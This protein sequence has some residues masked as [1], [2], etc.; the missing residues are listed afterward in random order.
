MR[1]ADARRR[2]ERLPSPLPR[3]RI[4]L[5]PTLILRGEPPEAFRRAMGGPVRDA[6]ALVL[7]YPGDD[8]EAHL[9]L[10]VRPSGDHAHAGQ[11]AL[12]GGKRE[13][14]EDFPDGT[15]LREA[16]EE[17]GLDAPRAG[18]S[19]MGRLDVVDVRVSGFLMVPVVAI[20]ERAPELVPHDREVAAILRVPVGRFLSDAPIEIIEEERGGLHLRYGAYPV[21]GHRVWGATGQVLA[22]LGAILSS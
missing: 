17:V 8:D 16:A 3:G 9:V 15:A 14:E 7:V 6:A 12:P 5:T 1:F 20:A 10:T 13:P 4:E 19:I 22:Q 2:L 11:V 21:E 18:V